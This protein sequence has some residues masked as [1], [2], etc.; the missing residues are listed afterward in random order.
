MVASCKHISSPKGRKDEKLFKLMNN[1][2]IR[3]NGLKLGV[4]TCLVTIR[5]ARIHSSLRAV[6]MEQTT[7][8]RRATLRRSL[9]S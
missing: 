4:R 6:V 5:V 1:V 2:G 9:P 8:L 3:E 7:G